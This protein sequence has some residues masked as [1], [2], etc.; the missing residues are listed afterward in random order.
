MTNDLG[1]YPQL[2]VLLGLPLCYGIAS[3][4]NSNTKIK[5]KIIVTKT[6]QMQD[7]HSATGKAKVSTIR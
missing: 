6:Q 2:N 3:S 4:N 1:F 7:L 5:K